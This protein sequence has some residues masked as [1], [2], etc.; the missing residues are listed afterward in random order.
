MFEG[1]KG[2]WIMPG[3]LVIIMILG[4][5]YYVNDS[6]QVSNEELIEH[7]ELHADLQETDDDTYVLEVEWDWT[8]TPLEGLFGD[9]YLGI[10]FYDENDQIITDV[11]I[12][13]ATLH[14]YYLDEVIETNQAEHADNGLIFS[15]SN[16]LDEHISYG[17]IGKAQ[18]IVE[19][20]HIEYAT[21]HL[22][23]TWMNHAPL[24]SRDATFSEVEFD[25]ASGIPYWVKKSSND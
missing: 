19:S 20:D 6:D 9:D 14:L 10:V 13:E 7:I 16:K 8:I 21:A 2:L 23:H 15:F 24:V 3:I 18:I 22:L 11:D 12:D 1:N 17:N 4:G 5:I 25:G